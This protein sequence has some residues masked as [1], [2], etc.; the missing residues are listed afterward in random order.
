MKRI[1]F[2]LFAV[3][4]GLNLSA[5]DDCG[6]G[7]IWDAETLKC[8]PDPENCGA[9]TYWNQLEA[10]CLPFDNCPEDLNEDG[11]IG[12]ADLLMLLSAYAQFCLCENDTDGDGVCN[13]D[14]VYGC[15]DPQACNYD[16]SATEEDGTCLQL[17]ECGVCGGEGIAEGTCD[18]DGTLPAENYNCDGTCISDANEDGICDELEI[19]G[20]TDSFACNF[21]PAATDDDGSCLTLDWTQQGA[22][23]DS[24]TLL[25]L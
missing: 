18:C 7:T 25:P 1:L 12:T 19:A 17:D 3:A 14:E 24:E 13:E 5:Q 16:V 15:N 21:N 8:V 22:D 11:V 9:G 10:Q 2:I 20:C 23:I 6:S 4:L